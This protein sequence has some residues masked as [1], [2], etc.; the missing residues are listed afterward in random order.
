MQIAHKIELN[1][2]NKQKTYFKKAGG[3]S[4]FVWNWGLAEWRRL[5]QENQKCAKGERIKISGISLKKKFNAL[6]KEKFPWIT[7]VT[8]Y[9][10]QQP[11]LEL[12][13]AQKRF[14]NKVG[15]KPVF[16]KKNKTKMSFY[17]GGDQ[18]RI[19]GKKIWIPKLGFVRLREKL[20]F[21]GHIQGI[22]V[23]RTADKWFVSIQV[24]TEIN[25]KKHESQVPIGIDLGIN[26]LATLSNGVAFIAPKP[27]KARLRRLKRKQRKLTK[28]RKGSKNYEKQ[29]HRI[30]KH[31]MK[32]ANIRKN[33]LHKITSWITYYYSAIGIED[34]NVRGMMANR[35]LA[36]SIGDLGFYEF[37]RQ[38]E[39]K[40]ARYG[41][42]LHVADR[43]LPSSKMCSRCGRINN[44]LRLCDRIYKCSCDFEVDRDLNAAINLEPRLDSKVPR[45]H[46][47][48]TPVEMTALQRQAGLVFVTSIG[49]SGSKRQAAQV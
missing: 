6:K 26:A 1:P 24:D 15:C 25:Y 17:V 5:Y 28:K 44:E 27:L 49:E 31:H 7:E 41:G 30:S 22:T 40:N 14:F 10:A 46:R 39:Y 48:C 29:K 33:Y 20:R 32:I 47:E 42:S 8:K 9:A 3:I 21:K 13:K 35:R 11:F 18:V 19:E 12:Q 38:L 2:N 37:K 45:V 34:L 43:F 36:R 4:R 16:K 23:S